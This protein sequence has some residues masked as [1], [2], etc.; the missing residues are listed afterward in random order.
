MMRPIQVGLAIFV[1]EAGTQTQELM[2][3]AT[4]TIAPILILYFLAQRQFTEG[5]MTSGLKG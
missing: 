1:T 3:A 4:M 2:A 5:I